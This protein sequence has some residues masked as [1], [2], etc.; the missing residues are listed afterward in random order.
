MRLRRLRPA[1]LTAGIRHSV[2][3]TFVLLPSRRDYSLR[4]FAAAKISRHLTLSCT[5]SFRLFIPIN[6]GASPPPQRGFHSVAILRVSFLPFLVICLGR[7]ILCYSIQLVTDCTLELHSRS[8]SR[9]Q[10]FRVGLI[11][12][13][14]TI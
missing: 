6:F 11:V 5:T 13:L 7:R 2:R 12:W 1:D 3:S 8:F 10:I 9:P 4:V 14:Y